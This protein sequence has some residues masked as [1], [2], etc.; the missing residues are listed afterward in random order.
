MIMDKFLF[1]RYC[2][3][4]GSSNVSSLAWVNDATGEIEEYV[5]SFYDEDNNYCNSCNSHVKLMTLP[6]MWELLED[7]PIDK[8]ECIEEDF[9]FFEKGT[10]RYSI[11]HWFDERCPNGLAVDLMGNKPNL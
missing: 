10:N 7:V 3:Q 4:C 2:P 1:T 9:L 5:G 11:W 8:D 6:E